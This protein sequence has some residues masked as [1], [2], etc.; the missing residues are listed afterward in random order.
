[1]QV[2]EPKCG[3][4]FDYGVTV[5]RSMPGLTGPHDGGLLQ[6]STALTVEPAQ[7]TA[8]WADCDEDPPPLQSTYVINQLAPSGSY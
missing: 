6:V 7:R 2:Q 4:Y 5:L 1:M 3:I 8:A